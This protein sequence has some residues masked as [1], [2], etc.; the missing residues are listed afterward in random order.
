MRC[1]HVSCTGDIGPFKI[2]SEGGC[3]RTPVSRAVAS[4]RR[5][6]LERCR[7]AACQPPLSLGSDNPLDKLGALLE[8]KL[9]CWRRSW[10]TGACCQLARLMTTFGGGRKSY[11]EGTGV[12][13][14]QAVVSWARPVEELKP[15]PRRVIP[16]RR[17]AGVRS[18]TYHRRRGL[19]DPR[20]GQPASLWGQAAAAVGIKVAECPDMAHM[21]RRHRCRNWRPRGPVHASFY[22]GSDVERL[23]RA[24]AIA[25]LAS[26]LDVSAGGV[27]FPTTVAKRTWQVWGMAFRRTQRFENGFDRNRSLRDSVWRPSSWSSRWFIVAKTAGSDDACRGERVRHGGETNRPDR[28]GQPDRRS[29]HGSAN[30]GRRWSDRRAGPSPAQ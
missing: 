19:V 15:R 30:P 27:R 6:W 8:R 1:N 20:T 14:D 11:A 4:A 26:F 28:P 9:P 16:A 5:R 12:L 2:N 3:W 22:K 21:W 25:G 24:R 7:G 13:S 29:S 18:Y 23:P 10:N 17:R